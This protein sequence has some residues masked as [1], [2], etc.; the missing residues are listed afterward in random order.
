MMANENRKQ[1]IVLNSLIID[2]SSKKKNRQK[3]AL[4]SSPNHKSFDKINGVGR[5]A[6]FLFPSPYNSL[7]IYINMVH[8]NNKF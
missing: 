1:K 6:Q 7:Q 3:K 5:K 2:S 8:K 4:S